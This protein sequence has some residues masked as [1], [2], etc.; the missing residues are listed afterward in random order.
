MNEILLQEVMD[1]FGIPRD[2]PND[3]DDEGQEPGP[4]EVLSFARRVGLAAAEASRSE[5]ADANL[6]Q[7]K[8]EIEKLRDELDYAQRGTNDR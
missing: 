8:D 7:Y 4:R 1:C 5:T 3:N 6:R 2:L